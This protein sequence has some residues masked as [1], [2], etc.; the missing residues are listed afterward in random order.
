MNYKQMFWEF[1]HYRFG[2]AGEGQADSIQALVEASPGLVLNVGCGLDGSKIARLAMHCEMQVAV[3]KDLDIVRA[4]RNACIDS[5]VEFVVAD[6]HKLPFVDSCANHV[7]ALGLFADVPDPVLV[8][9][10]F[11]RVLKS[12]GHV[13]ITNSVSR[14]IETHKAA[15]EKAGLTLAEEAEGYCPAASGEIKRRYLLIFT[16]D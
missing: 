10:E 11:Y 2:L 15:A 4:A 13:M 12:R 3:D 8:F 9:R 14:S 5:N 6:A 7:V 16:T 1:H